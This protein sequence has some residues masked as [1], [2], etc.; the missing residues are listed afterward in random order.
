[1]PNVRLSE[2]AYKW[3]QEYADGRPLGK[4]VERLLASIDSIRY[5]T[6]QVREGKV[7]THEEVFPEPPAPQADTNSTPPGI[8]F[9][10]DARAIMEKVLEDQGKPSCTCTKAERRRPKGKLGPHKLGCPAREA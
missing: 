9:P 4:A 5:A 6:E 7:L 10:L 3:L 1:M 2:E 8:A